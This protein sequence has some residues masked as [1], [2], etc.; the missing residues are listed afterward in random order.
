MNSFTIALEYRV[1]V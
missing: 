1:F